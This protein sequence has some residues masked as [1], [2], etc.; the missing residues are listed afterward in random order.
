MGKVGVHDRQAQ[1]AKHHLKKGAVLGVIVSI[2]SDPTALQRNS[3]LGSI[4][5][6]RYMD[7]VMA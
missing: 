4:P 2:Q 6:Q 1:V 5:S 7:P 3:R